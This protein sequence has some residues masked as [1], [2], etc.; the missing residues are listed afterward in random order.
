V[1]T[2]ALVGPLITLLVVTLLAACSGR[3]KQSAAGTFRP[4]GVGDTVPR[5]QAITFA[6]DT[7]NIGGR[8]PPTLVN[9]WATWCESC[10]EEMQDL[11]S[12]ARDFKGKG[13]RVVAI[14]VDEGDG[15]RV[16]RFVN[17]EHLTM[18]IAHDPSAEVS[19][20]LSTVGVPESYLIDTTGRLTWHQVGGLHSNPNAARA[21]VANILRR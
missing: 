20:R 13:L 11:E 12:I 16:R 19:R 2:G 8:E 6:G 21:A 5:F 7:M 9:V 3:G 1:R 18:P 10:R 4:L 14:S 17:A 15:T